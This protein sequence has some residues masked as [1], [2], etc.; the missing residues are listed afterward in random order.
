MTSV[1]SKTDKC[2]AF[3]DYL[4]AQCERDK[5]FA[6][7]LRRADNSATEYQCWETLAKFN[8]N[9]DF[10]SERLPH[11]LIAAAVAKSRSDSN[12]TLPLGKAI[13]LA[14]NDGVKSDQANMRLRRLLACHDVEEVCRILRPLI[15]LIQSRVTLPL[16]FTA[17]L[18][19]LVWFN[20][21]PQRA[22]ARW[23]QQF[24]QSER[25]GQVAEGQY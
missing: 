3:I 20:H 15:T 19:D 24:Y 17:L 2:S 4:F 7:R 6:A 16:D 25:S 8:I 13:A 11:A 18:K 23:A 5:G 10:S 22:R 14:F 9:L 21:D 1:P 12:G